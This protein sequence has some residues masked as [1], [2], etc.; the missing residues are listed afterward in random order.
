MPAD[1][2]C[3]RSVTLLIIEHDTP[4]WAYP[5][6]TQT[7]RDEVIDKIAELQNSSISDAQARAYVEWL[8]AR[9]HGPLVASAAHAWLATAM[10]AE[11]PAGATAR[12]RSKSR[13]ATAISLA[14]VSLQLDGS[15]GPQALRVLVDLLV[16]GRLCSLLWSAISTKKK[17]CEVN[18][19]FLTLNELCGL[20]FRSI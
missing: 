8:A 9:G 11:V 19:H 18:L 10:H 1:P 3:V 6:E 12:G 16:S 5:C 20:S 7:Q 4:H 2:M 15:C 13:K 14:D 17:D